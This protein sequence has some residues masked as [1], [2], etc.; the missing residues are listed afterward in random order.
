VGEPDAAALNVAV[1]PDA[2]DVLEGFDVIATGVGVADV[3][4]SVA[5]V[6]S[7]LP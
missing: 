1:D 3:T 6:V 4:V 5:A 2:T 7:A